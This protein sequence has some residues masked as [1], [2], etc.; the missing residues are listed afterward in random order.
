MAPKRSQASAVSRESTPSATVTQTVPASTPIRTANKNQ[1]PA[2]IALGIWENYL[3]KTPQRTKLIDVFMAFLVV[4]GVLQ[5]VYCVIAGNYPFNAFLSGFSATVGQFVLTAS[6]RIQ[7]NV[8]NKA[9][10]TSVSQ[11]RA[12][13]DYVFGSLILHFFCVNFIN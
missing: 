5:F 4:V 9:D 3:D 10:F 7:T 8:E 1:S 2:E 12:F 11:E 6:L 13:A